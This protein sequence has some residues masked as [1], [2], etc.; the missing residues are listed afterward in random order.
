MPEP[1]EAKVWRPPTGPAL[2]IAATTSYQESLIH[3]S[4]ALA[5]ICP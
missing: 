2:D 4:V 5:T 1:P 3:L